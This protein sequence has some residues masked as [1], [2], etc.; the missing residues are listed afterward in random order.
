MLKNNYCVNCKWHTT[1]NPVTLADRKLGEVIHKC[2]HDELFI[3]NLV[4]GEIKKYIDDC[5]NVRY[6]EHKC[7]KEGNWFE[8]K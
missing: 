6:N 1:T 7:G 8:A 4:T 5:N 2:E 3:E